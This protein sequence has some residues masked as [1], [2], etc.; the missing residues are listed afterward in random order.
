MKP[1]AKP[2]RPAPK[3][4]FVKLSPAYLAAVRGARR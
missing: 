1:R 4:E 3:R 2:P